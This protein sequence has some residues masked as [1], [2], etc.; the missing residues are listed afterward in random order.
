ML[1]DLHIDD[2]HEIKYRVKECPSFLKYNSLR[3]ICIW[4]SAI[5]KHTGH[6]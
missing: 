2:S 4:F 6:K 5:R 1:L 3:L